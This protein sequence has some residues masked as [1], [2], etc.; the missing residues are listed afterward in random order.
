LEP[1]RYELLLEESSLRRVEQ[2][3]LQLGKP[4]RFEFAPLTPP[5]GSP[6]EPKFT[7]AETSPSRTQAVVGFVVLGAGVLTAGAAVFL[8]LK[9]VN[10]KDEYYDT[11]F[12]DRDAR[13]RA[14]NLRFGTNVA[15]AG[16]GA[17]GV[18]GSLL[19]VTSPSLK[20]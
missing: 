15:W 16:A 7:Q 13:E 14:A 20:F 4:A 3:E 1:G 5:F 17:L 6:P 11:D 9:A 12:T 18:T 10:A 8:G 2:L 19:L